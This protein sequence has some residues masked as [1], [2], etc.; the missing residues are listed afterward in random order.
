M[1]ATMPILNLPT[2]DGN[3]WSK[4]EGGYLVPTKNVNPAAPEGF[5]ELTTCKCKKGCKTNRCACRKN[6]LLCSDACY[7]GDDCENTD[8]GS[9]SDDSDD[10]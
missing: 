9:I 1:N 5:V 2:P 7:C 4:D 6:D 8:R 3:G 10:E